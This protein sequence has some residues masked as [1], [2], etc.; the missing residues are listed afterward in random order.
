MS[1]KT[2]LPPWVFNLHRLDLGI[3]RQLAE[4]IQARIF[5]G[6]HAMLSVVRFEPNS[7]GAIHS[8][9]E[10]QWGILLEGEC[11]RIQAG[12]EVAM[13]AGDF[14]H[15]PGGCRTGSAPGR[16]PPS[17]STSSVRR[18]ASTGTRGRGSARRVASSSVVSDVGR[19]SERTSITS[20]RGGFRVVLAPLSEHVLADTGDEG[21]ASHENASVGGPVRGRPRDVPVCELHQRA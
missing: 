5:A 13:K 14:W 17:C 18:G 21:G 6:E 4:G 16:G 3:P 9:P 20:S 1:S 15:T 7:T 8:H 12:E 10:E 11:V 19:L 2:S